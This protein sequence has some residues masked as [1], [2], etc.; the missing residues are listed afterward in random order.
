MQNKLQTAIVAGLILFA[1]I[2]TS[3]SRTSYHTKSVGYNSNS[4]GYYFK[5]KR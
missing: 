3:C 1:L 4:C 2:A 5:H